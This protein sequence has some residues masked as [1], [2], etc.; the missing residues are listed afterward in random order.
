MSGCLGAVLLILI[1]F[2]ILYLALNMLVWAICTVFGL[3]FSH[4]F[5]IGILAIVGIIAIIK[6]LLK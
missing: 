3:V 1:V 6:K 4:G 5:A 2:A